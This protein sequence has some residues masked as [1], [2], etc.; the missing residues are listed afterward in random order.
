MKTQQEARF[1][2]LAGS[3]LNLYFIN[4]LPPYLNTTVIQ[5]HFGGGL[6]LQSSVKLNW[7]LIKKELAFGGQALMR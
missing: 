7:D 5:I 2:K 6:I 3:T 4:H 1:E